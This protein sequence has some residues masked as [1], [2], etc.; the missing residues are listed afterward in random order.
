MKGEISANNKSGVSDSMQMTRTANI[1]P[2]LRIGSHLSGRNR[3]DWSSDSGRIL[4]RKIILRTSG[5]K[6]APKVGQELFGNGCDWHVFERS[7]SHYLTL[8][9]PSCENLDFARAL[10]QFAVKL[11]T[12]SARS[13]Y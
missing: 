9:V 7:D 13:V 10:R 8:V 12:V 2:W 5:V 4:T 1:V 6:R 11:V 3:N